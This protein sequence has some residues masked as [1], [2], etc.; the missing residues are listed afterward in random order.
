MKLNTE[1]EYVSFSEDEQIFGFEIIGTNSLFQICDGVWGPHIVED[2]QKIFLFMQKRKKHGKGISTE[3][4]LIQILSH[5]K[6]DFTDI[7]KIF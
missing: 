1:V 5:C 6:R 2:K 7:W 4:E 3:E